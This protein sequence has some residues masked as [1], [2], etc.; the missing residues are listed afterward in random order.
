MGW[1]PVILSLAV[2]IAF[3]WS[4][5]KMPSILKDWADKDQE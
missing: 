1:L 2:L 5:S 4:W 3:V